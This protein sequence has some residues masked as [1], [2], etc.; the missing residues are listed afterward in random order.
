LSLQKK[1]AII[2]PDHKFLSIRQ[3]AELIALH[4]SSYYYRPA[5]ES[6]ENLHL[7]KV[8]DEEYTKHPFYGSR[9]MTEVLKRF[10][11]KINRKRVQRLMA[12]MGIEGICPKRNLSKAAQEFKK[13]PYLLK[14]YNIEKPNEVWSTDITYIRLKT[15]FMYLTA[16]LDWYSRYVLSWRLSNSLEGGFCIEAL[17]EAL[18]KGC[19][20]IFNTD[21]GVQYTAKHFTDILEKKNIRVSMDGKGRALDNIFTERFW[22]SLKYEDIY[23][24]EYKNG[25]EL[26]VG[27]KEYIAFY[28]EERLHQS[29]NYR[30]PN[31]VHWLSPPWGREVS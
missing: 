10:N 7:M 8:M 20:E 22:R 24:K 15:G 13:Y 16:V 17:E 28:N 3:Q 18:E 12:L 26:K 23:L 21:Q 9:R 6:E 29:L 4:R 11:Y 5:I 1:R 31:E 25:Q 30:T 19:P 27:L 2:E 14:G